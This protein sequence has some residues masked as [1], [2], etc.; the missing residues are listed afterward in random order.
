MRKLRSQ[1]EIIASWHSKNNS[2]LVSICCATYNHVSFIE[3]ALNSFLSQKTTFPFEVI[4]RDDASTD[5][6]S[7]ILWS[8]QQQYPDIIRVI[9]NPIN[10]FQ[11]GE[12]AIHCWSQLV[13]GEFVSL[14]EGDDFWI[15]QDKL[16][17]QID[18]LGR[19]P[20]AVA[21]LAGT[22]V[23]EQRKDGCL[24]VIRETGT[25]ND[26][27]LTFENINKTY[28]HTSTYTIRAD[29]LAEITTKFFSGH[30]FFG[31]TALRA[32]LVSIGPI[33]ALKEIVSVY[34][35]T[36][37]GTWTS[38]D[39]ES[40][41][42]W[43]CK[44]AKKLSSML[45]GKHAR[46]Q[47]ISLFVNEYALLKIYIRRHKGTLAAKLVLSLLGKCHIFIPFYLKAKWKLIR[48]PST[49]V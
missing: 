19:Y 3:D 9:V 12:R 35:I 30:V 48:E 28:Y 17:K 32:I 22:R 26:E 46:R 24:V 29:I 23:C 34:R 39:R 5:G 2:P 25:G 41:L 40:Q 16:Q 13:R 43:E 11:H 31:D 20:N 18:L 37:N 38:L 45:E 4:V 44:A 27:K 8:Y 42:L 15:T 6:T 1:E 47:K 10:M 36:Q 7:A 33:L 49:D 21:C 14:C